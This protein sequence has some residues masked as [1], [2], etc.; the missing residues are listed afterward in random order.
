MLTFISSNHINIKRKPSFRCNDDEKIQYRALDGN[1]RLWRV[2]EN[3][4]SI[5]VI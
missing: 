4:S 5:R 3:V 1:L 2:K